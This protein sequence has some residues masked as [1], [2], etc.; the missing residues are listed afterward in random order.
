MTTEAYIPGDPNFAAFQMGDTMPRPLTAMAL[1]ID[2]KC[3]QRVAAISGIALDVNLPDG[4]DLV[5]R[6]RCGKEW[7]IAAQG[8]AVK[9]KLQAMED[10]ARA[11]GD[12]ALAAPTPPAE[13]LPTAPEVPAGEDPQAYSKSL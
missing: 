13:S 2:C 3:G 5:G 9:A 12:L 7:S 4:Q 1:V 6:C 11:A 8:A 10:E